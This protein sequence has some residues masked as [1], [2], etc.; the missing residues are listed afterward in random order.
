MTE[1][2]PY[3]RVKQEFGFDEV[4]PLEPEQ[5]LMEGHDIYYEE[6]GKGYKGYKGDNFPLEP[7]GYY[8]FDG[9][10]IEL[11]NLDPNHPYQCCICMKRYKSQGSLQNHRSLY[12]RDIIG[13]K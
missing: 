5:M 9:G 4:I 6:K 11:G 10:D 2:E 7:N 3:G 8:G 1:L 12:H 13:Q